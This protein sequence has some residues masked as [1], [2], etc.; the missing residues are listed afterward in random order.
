MPG[1]RAVLDASAIVAL[2]LGE[3]G[4]ATVGR[5]VAAG[6]ATTTPTGMAEALIT[7]HRKGY[8][9]ARSELFD[10]L[11]QLGLGVEPLIPDDAPEIA[12]LLERSDALAPAGPPGTAVG[13][14]SLGDA[15]CLAVAS[16][17][18]VP[19]VV[20]DGTWEILGVPGLQILPFR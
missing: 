1:A 18:G 3:R 7:C 17:L 19:A 20:S 15:V 6:V 8:G 4:A 14:L 10:D 12:F 13:R 5:V 11:G 2:V 16:R 9:A